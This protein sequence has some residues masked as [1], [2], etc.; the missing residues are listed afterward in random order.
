MEIN[1]EFIINFHLDR[2]REK[3]GIKEILNL[4]EM[5]LAIDSNYS[6]YYRAIERNELENFP[7]PIDEKTSKRSNK[8]YKNRKYSVL[9]IVEFKIQGKKKYCE[10]KR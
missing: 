9:D 3:V 4:H 1:N 6:A 7:S 10:K 5:L 8:N 2:I